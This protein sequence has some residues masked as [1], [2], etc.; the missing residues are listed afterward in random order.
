MTT[1]YGALVGAIKQAEP[2]RQVPN[3]RE[4]IEQQV[5]VRDRIELAA[6]PAND[7]VELAVLPWETK[8]DPYQSDFSFDD[9]G[10]GVTF[11]VGDVTYPTALCN[12]Q[13]VATA[14][15]TAKICKSV[16]IA[17]YWMPLWE[18]LGYAS[19]EAAQLVG[20]QCQ[21]LGKIGT[22]AATGTVAWQITGV[23]HLV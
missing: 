11:S 19:L 13:D 14:A 6:A 12:V 8:I 7:V 1:R 23:K 5:L 18:M 15:G 3:G 9:L 17:K 10:T 20:R 4:N 16:D 22:A 21:L 2:F